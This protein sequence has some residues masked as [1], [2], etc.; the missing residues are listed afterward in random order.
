MADT[1]QHLA[2]PNY[3]FRLFCVGSG[4][5]DEE[6]LQQLTP[7]GPRQCFSASKLCL[8]ALSFS[9]IQFV[10]LSDRNLNVVSLRVS[11]RNFVTVHAYMQLSRIAAPLINY[12]VAFCQEQRMLD[13]ENSE[14]VY[15]KLMR[16][17]QH[18][19]HRQKKP[20]IKSERSYSLVYFKVKF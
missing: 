5:V 1:C 13:S 17:H 16:C 18:P 19:L 10:R 15:L 2:S 20:K 7:R 9:P 14:L 8:N 4:M 11:Q 3:S 6:L 12:I